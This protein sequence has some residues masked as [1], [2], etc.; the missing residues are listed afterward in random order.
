MPRLVPF[1]VGLLVLPEAAGAASPQTIA[2]GYWE[3]TNRVLSPIGHRKTEM[4]CIRPAD[5]AKFMEGPGNH[6][7]RCTYPTKVFSKGQ[8]RLKGSCKSRDSA[9]FPIEGAGTYTR[10]SFYLDAHAVAPLGPLR[11]PVHA[12]TEARRIADVCPAPEATPAPS[13]DEA[14]N[15]A[16]PAAAEAGGTPSVQ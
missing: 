3:T 14:G 8:I 6:I 11:L 7:Y 16:P 13:A 15:A 9:P 12:V 10:D 2:P 1:L 5:V 4:R